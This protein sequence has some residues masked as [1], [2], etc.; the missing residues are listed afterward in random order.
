MSRYEYLILELDVFSQTAEYA[1][2]AV[3]C[4]AQNREKSLTTHQ[5]ADLTRVP[6]GYLSKVL[7]ILA[8]SSIFSSRRG[9][10]G[11]FVLAVAPDELTI[12]PVLAAVD[13]VQRINTCPL[14][15]PSHGKVLCPLH[16]KLDDAMALIEKS[17]GDTTVAEVVRTPSKSTPLCEVTIGRSSLGT[18]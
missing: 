3:V 14:G 17:L 5:I 7:Q 2:R 16:R 1:L 18:M 12:L 9:L 4:L 15:L 13:P 10:H 8:K 6:M 11:G